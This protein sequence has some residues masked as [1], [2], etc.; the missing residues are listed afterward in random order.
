M[1]R[2]LILIGLIFVTFGY[3]ELC[4]FRI[5]NV[6]VSKYLFRLHECFIVIFYVIYKE[7]L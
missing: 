3:I 5:N 4:I 1:M 7:I 2:I 6:R